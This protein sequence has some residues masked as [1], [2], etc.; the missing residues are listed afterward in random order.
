MFDIQNRGIW[1]IEVKWLKGDI[2]CAMRQHICKHPVETRS[3]SQTTVFWS[4]H[5][6]LRSL[7]ANF[8]HVYVHLLMMKLDDA[9]CWPFSSS[10]SIGKKKKEDKKETGDEEWNNSK[11]CLKKEGFSHM[12]RQFNLNF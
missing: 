2:P 7:Q 11:K 10:M 8:L 4:G 12:I 1:F 5:L 6:Q 9:C 3:G